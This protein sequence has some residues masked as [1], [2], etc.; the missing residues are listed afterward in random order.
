MG[1]DV[2][3]KGVALT[4]FAILLTPHLGVAQ[5]KIRCGARKLRC[6]IVINAWSKILDNHLKNDNSTRSRVALR[7][8][9]V[10]CR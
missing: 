2:S 1:A 8:F 6:E 3:Q 10:A 9:G 7:N 4:Y 5:G